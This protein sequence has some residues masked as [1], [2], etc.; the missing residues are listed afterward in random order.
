MGFCNNI[1]PTCDVCFEVLYGKCNDVLTLSIGLTP[2]TTFFLNLTDKFD[3]ITPLT[4]T[5]DSSGDFT[6]TQTWTE[7]FGDVEVEI[8][9]DAGRTILI[10]VIQN[11]NIYNCILLVQ[12]L[13]GSNNI[14]PALFSPNDIANLLVWLRSDMGVTKDGSD[15]VSLWADQSSNGNDVV[16]AVGSKQPTWLSSQ[17]DSKPAISFD[18]VDDLLKSVS[19]IWNQP[20]TIYVVFKQVSWSVTEI[21]MD[22]DGVAGAALQQITSPPRLQLN[23]GGG[24]L[25]LA[26]FTIGTFFIAT[27]IFNGVNSV[28]QNG[29]TAEATGNAGVNNMSGLTLGGLGSDTLWGNVDIT[30]VIG[31]AGVHTTAQR[32]EVKAYLKTRYPSL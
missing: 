21:L 23:A 12:E 15:A 26:T 16:Q 20:E 8:F 7:F 31:Y 28:F 2:S 6:I 24:T 4:V 32:T 29:D 5:T 19:F 18:G 27:V 30:E 22:G 1:T 17:L 9:S 3:I 11:S 14:N 25:L 10:T 13:S